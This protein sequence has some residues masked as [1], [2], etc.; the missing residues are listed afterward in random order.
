MNQPNEH[1]SEH[2]SIE[3][4]LFI[5]ASPEVVYDVVS[6][7]EHMAN[8]YVDAA[9]Y[10]AT[11]GSTG[12]LAFSNKE[13]RRVEVP[14]EVVEA[15]PGKRF[16]FRWIAPPAP[17]LLP[18]GTDLT[19]ANSLLVTFE[20]TAQPGGT[21]L[22]VIES[23]ARELGWEAAVLEHYYTDHSE[24]WAVL[25]GRMQTYAVGLAK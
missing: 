1:S 15:V 10:E 9:E 21:L 18:V 5:E 16:S 23:G 3:Q 11:P 25:L 13:R 19:P 17:D 7:P 14:I 22:R 6:S 2:G 8:W 4:S 24:G 20:L 12:H